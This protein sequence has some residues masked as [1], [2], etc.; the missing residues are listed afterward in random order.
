[1]DKTVEKIIPGR[2]NRKL[3]EHVSQIVTWRNDG[4]SVADIHRALGLIGVAAGYSSVRREVKKLE[5]KHTSA[6]KA[7]TPTRNQTAPPAPI[8]PSKAAY[9]DV[10]TFFNQTPSNPILDKIAKSKKP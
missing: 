10:D 6:P 1:M 7:R 8:A 3:R 2:P 4:F 5:S 9:V